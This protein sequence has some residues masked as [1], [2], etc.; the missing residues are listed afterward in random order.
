MSFQPGPRPAW[1]FA[2]PA[3]FIFIWSS[4][5]IAAKFAATAADPLTFLCVRY[6]GST[7][8]MV[9]LAGWAR[10][11]WPSAPHAVRIALAGILMQAVYLGGVWV[12]VRHGMSAGVAALIVNLQPV[13]TAA[14]GPL[15][16]ERVTARQWGGLG[17]GVVGVGL[18]VSNKIVDASMPAYTVG[19][20]L[21]SLIGITVGLLYQK[22][23]VPAF[24][25]RTGQAIQFAASL[26]VTLPFAWLFESH[27]FDVNL[28]SLL[29]LAW[30][31]FVLTGVGITLL[32]LMMRHGDA[33]RVTSYMYLAPAVTALM[34]WPLFG[35][36]FGA[37]ALLGMGIT[38]AGVALVVTRSKRGELT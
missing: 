12:S 32:F 9:L 27:R 4:G 16:G 33:T 19:L 36:T 6:V 20:T 22:R 15:I 38:I 25:L 8:L 2:A 23:N 10:A 24:D 5:Y 21:L 26:V 18:V 35:E 31:I 11:T 34:A 1:L 28:T 29:T 3:L 14:A 17:L 7:V 30:S 13:L 37:V